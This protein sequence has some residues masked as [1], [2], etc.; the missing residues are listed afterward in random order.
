MDIAKTVRLTPGHYVVAVSGGVDSMVLLDILA[1]IHVGKDSPVKLTVAHF[2]HGI[3]DT[4]HFDRMLVHEVAKSH[5]LPFVYG[6]GELGPDVSESKARDARYEFLRKVQKQAGARGIITAHHLD[7]SVETAVMN[8]MRGTGRKGITSLKTHQGIHRPLLH[9]A[10]HSLRSYAEA[11]GLTWNE[12]ST[13]QNQDYKRNY[14]RHSIL[15]KIKAKS[16]QEYHRLMTIIRRQRE[17]N[18]AID[19]Q[20]GNLLHLQPSR[21]SLRR[22]DVIALPYKVACEL[23]AEWLR[24]NGKRQLSRW[25]VERL[26]V[27]IRTAQPNTAILLDS[28]AKVSFSKAEAEFRLV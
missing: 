1:K 24:E 12:D 14:V 3:R 9:V 15:P 19:Q 8:L 20:L 6:E 28:S 2:D 11:N 18:H 21:S 5:G 22:R 26:T 25:L 27:A 17:L 23:V 10:K 13:N 4:S 7:D 16:P